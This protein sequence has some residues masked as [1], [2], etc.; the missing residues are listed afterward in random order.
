MFI[1]GQ[2][3]GGYDATSKLHNQGK[4]M[5][6][7][8][9]KFFSSSF[10]QF[11]L[12]NIMS[13]KAKVNT[14]NGSMY[15]KPK[16]GEPIDQF[17]NE[18]IKTSRVV[19]FSKTTCPYCAKTKELFKSLNESYISV[20]LDQIDE[21]AAIRDYLYEKTGQKT[22]PN[23]YVK[24]THLGGCDN[25]LKAHTEGRLAKLLNQEEVKDDTQYDYD[26]VVIGGGSGGLAC[27][28]AAAANGAK[29]AVLDFVKPT[30]IGTTWGLGG[31]CVNVGCIPKNLCIKVLY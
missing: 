5:P 16:A 7:L 6:L 15:T 21:G 19:I 30:P 10:S 13:R 11:Y 20:E 14:E 4:L 31:T 27:S 17:V 25:T 26:M 12:F 29:V 22:V 3:I 2:H 9:S 18:L 1:K 24:G 8:E 28:K 23:V